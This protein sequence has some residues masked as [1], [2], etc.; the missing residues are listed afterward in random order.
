[1]P[2]RSTR[3]LTTLSVHY[4]KPLSRYEIAMETND[5]L[6]YVGLIKADSM[7]SLIEFIARKIEIFEQP[8]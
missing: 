3:R 4:C 5:G 8:S 1:M 7:R 2:N 6:E